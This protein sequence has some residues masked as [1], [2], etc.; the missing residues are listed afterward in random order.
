MTRRLPWRT[1]R[2]YALIALAGF[3]TAYLLVALFVLPGDRSGG[4]IQAPSLVGLSLEDARRVLD[5]LGLGFS[6]GEERRSATAPRH[7][8]LAQNPRPGTSLARN[9][10][11]RVDVS[12]GPRQV[13]VPSVAGLT[14]DEARRIL[15]DS[16]LAAGSTQDEVSTAPR[17]EVLRSQPDAGRFV[18]EG[19]PVDLIVSGGPPEL[20][21]PDVVGRNPADA[22]AVLNQL[23]LTRVR[24]DSQPGTG[25]D[26]VVL[27]QLPAAGT[28]LRLTDR[29]ALRVGSRP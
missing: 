12:A 5:S 29:I 1:I 10:S 7:T 23:G 19:S 20:T 24:V 18:G 26:A 14:V 17:G 16:G 2:F 27:G 28:G 6:L 21:M 25:V 8:V 11:V 22:L 4:R 9:A 3:A 15:G 13:R